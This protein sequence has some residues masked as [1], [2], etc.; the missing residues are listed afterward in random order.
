MD[1]RDSVGAALG[2]LAC[3]A[4]QGY[5]TLT[6]NNPVLKAALGGAIPEI[7]SYLLERLYCNKDPYTQPFKPGPCPRRYSIT[8][9][10]RIQGSPIT[11]QNGTFTSTGSAWGP[12]SGATV[13]RLADA[14]GP[15]DDR[16]FI[17][18]FN[19]GPTNIARGDG[20]VTVLAGPGSIHRIAEIVILNT[21]ST[22]FPGDESIPCDVD[23][24]P[25]PYRPDDFTYRVPIT[26][27]PPGGVSVTI[28]LIGIVGLFYVNV[29]A[30]LVMPVTFKLD[31]RAN[32]SPTFNFNFQA[33]LNLNTG[34]TE[35]NWIE[36]DS[37][38]PVPPALPPTSRPPLTDPDSPAPPSP[39]SIPD[40]EPDPEDAA[41][42]RRLVGV[43]VTSTVTEA[44]LRAST[45]FQGS[46]PDI[47][48]PSLGFISFAIRTGSGAVGWTNDIPVK[49]LRA[50]VPVPANCSAIRAEGTPNRDITWVITPVYERALVLAGGE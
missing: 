20:A 9:T 4:A 25:P 10:Y 36:D 23:Q 34:D 16:F 11:G 48:V 31:A 1:F 37:V 40:V 41:E 29:D 13:R 44:M 3:S 14:G 19:Y 18:I 49:N 35:I 17:E 6:R 45:I 12:I 38:N 21:E 28:P 27:T 22:E 5:R 32:I 46:N 39:P 7:G 33:N 8:V 26:Y 43:I 15:S 42:G 47:Y 50:Y 24:P 2:Q 30:K